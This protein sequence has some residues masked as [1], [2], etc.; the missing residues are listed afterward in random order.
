MRYTVMVIREVWSTTSVVADSEEEAQEE[1]TKRYGT[2]QLKEGT[3]PVEDDIRTYV[4]SE[5]EPE[6]DFDPRS[7]S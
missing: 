4:I 7:R 3:L 6:L 2:R 1:V 5:E